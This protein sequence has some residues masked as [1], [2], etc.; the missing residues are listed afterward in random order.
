MGSTPKFL[1]SSRVN[2]H[3][4]G[5]Y[6]KWSLKLSS[7]FQILLYFENP[8]VCYIIIIIM[9][10]FLIEAVYHF[11]CI[12]YKLVLFSCSK[13]YAGLMMLLDC[14]DGSDENDGTVSCPNT[15]VMGGDFS[16]QTRNYVSQD[17]L[18]SFGRKVTKDV[19]NRE[20]PVQKVKGKLLLIVKL[21]AMPYPGRES[22]ITVYVALLFQV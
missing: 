19:V 3:I 9:S 4:C 22:E 14:C 11:C 8:S 13:C 18:D 5:K 21:F 10:S 15:C 12:L 1:F 20:D 2:D 7:H 6:C 17:N 16:Y